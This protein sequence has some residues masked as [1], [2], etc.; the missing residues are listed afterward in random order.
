[1]RPKRPLTV[2]HELGQSSLMF[3]VHPTLTEQHI[4]LTCKTVETVMNHAT[5]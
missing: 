3:L 4:D 1:M 5:A 2:A